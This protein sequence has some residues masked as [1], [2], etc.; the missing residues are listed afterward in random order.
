MN[1]MP[2]PDFP[3]GGL[4]MGRKGIFDAFSKGQG[5]IKLRGKIEQESSPKDEFLVVTEIPFMVQKNRL[6]EEVSKLVRD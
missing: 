5:S 4:I 6:L 3:T 1:I 2:G